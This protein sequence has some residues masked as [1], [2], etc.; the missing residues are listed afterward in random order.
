MYM[1]EFFYLFEILELFLFYLYRR[2]GKGDKK[3]FKLN[4]FLF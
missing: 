1:Y 4:D 2:E 3:K